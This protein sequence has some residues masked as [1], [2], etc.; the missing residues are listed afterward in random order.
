MFQVPTIPL[1]QL[2]LHFRRSSIPQLV[3]QHFVTVHHSFT[4]LSLQLENQ[5]VQ[6]LLQGH[7]LHSFSLLQQGD[8]H[9]S[10]VDCRQPMALPPSVDQ[11]FQQL[12]AIQT[13][14]QLVKEVMI[15]LPHQVR[16][17]ISPARPPR[18]RWLAKLGLRRVEHQQLP[19]SCSLLLPFESS[20]PV[21]VLQ[22][23]SPPRSELAGP[24]RWLTQ[25]P[26]D[27]L[28]VQVPR[29]EHWLE[30]Q[31]FR[32]GGVQRLPNPT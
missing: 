8:S 9:C 12:A 4:D 10:I 29:L 32:R 27:Q 28:Q 11:N 14:I 17:L 15:V 22:P 20:R 24:A 21:Q 7:P 25:L 6:P 2:P 26:L 13:H 5:L 18:Q 23:S 31:H 16:K 3:R 1:I 30:G 19:H